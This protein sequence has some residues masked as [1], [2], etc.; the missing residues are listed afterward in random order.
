MVYRANNEFRQVLR[1]AGPGVTSAIYGVVYDFS[2]GALGALDVHIRSV[3]WISIRQMFELHLWLCRATVLIAPELHDL[4]NRFGF[5][6]F[7][8]QHL[9]ALEFHQRISGPVDHHHGNAAL[10]MAF[11]NGS[12]SHRSGDRCN[13]SDF[14]GEAAGQCE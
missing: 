6:A 1:S 3:V 12:N 14:V 13:S 10:R 11:F 9:A 8:A 2:A 4:V 5:A 7:T